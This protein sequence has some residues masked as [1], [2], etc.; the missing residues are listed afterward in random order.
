MERLRLQAD[1]F[2]RQGRLQD[3]KMETTIEELKQ[4]RRQMEARDR[5]TRLQGLKST[6]G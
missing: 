1:W 5:T 4:V 6:R 2:R 3:D